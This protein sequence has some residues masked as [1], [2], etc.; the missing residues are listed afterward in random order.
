MWLFQTLAIILCV[1]DMVVGLQECVC[2]IERAH[3]S[4]TEAVM[5]LTPDLGILIT[6]VWIKS[7]LAILYFGHL[8]ATQVCP[9]PEDVQTMFLL[10][11]P[12]VYSQLL[13][14]MEFPLD[15]LKNSVKGFQGTK[16]YIFTITSVEYLPSDIF[17]NPDH[18]ASE[19]LQIEQRPALPIL[20]MIPSL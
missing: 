10:L 12:R 9:P 6:H 5:S 16:L 3:K 1:G 14:V 17:E 13:T 18:P 19:H 2:D 7:I 8:S 20:A 11:E 15:Q 4:L